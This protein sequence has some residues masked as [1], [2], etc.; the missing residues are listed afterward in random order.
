MKEEKV[1]MEDV[2]QPNTIAQG[3]RKD[4]VI[5]RFTREEKKKAKLD[6]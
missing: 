1:K 6:I 4:P 3:N 5:K 2:E